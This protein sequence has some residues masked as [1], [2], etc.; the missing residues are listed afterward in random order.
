MSITQH[1]IDQLKEIYK[2]QFGGDLSDEEAWEMGIRLVNLFR[3][4]LGDKQE[5]IE[6]KKVRTL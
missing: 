3:L 2:R 6:L 5:P 1:D 4:L